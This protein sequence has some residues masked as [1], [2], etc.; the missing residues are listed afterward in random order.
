[1]VLFLLM[2]FLYYISIDIAVPIPRS[3]ILPIVSILYGLPLFLTSMRLGVSPKVVWR[4]WTALTVAFALSVVSFLYAVGTEVLP[5]P[6]DEASPSLPVRVM[7]YNIHSAY[8]IEGR[9]NPEEIARVIEASGAD[10][11]ALQ[12]VSRGWLI[13][14]ST[15]LASW[16]ARRLNMDVLFKGTTGPV[17]GNAIL[18]RYPIMD[19][20]SG[21]LPLD[22]SLLGRGYLWAKIDVGARQP[23]QIIA[24]H[25]HHVEGE[26][27]I[28]LAQVPVL[29][30]YWDH[31]PRSII[32]GD[33]NA[34]PGVAEIALFFQAGLIDSWSEVGSGDGY[35]YSSGDPYQRIDWIWHT[36]D[37]VASDVEILQST[38]SDHLPVVATVDETH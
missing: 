19:H 21:A 32:M 34:E 7:T 37:L 6:G 36:Q 26:G 31:A 17:W 2:A 13:E 10:I 15:D 23:L 22:G 20:G 18:T 35:T 25:L 9:Q 3:T 33:M 11:I 5:R 27:E 14:G 1:M 28:R 24:T 8:N 38:A 30:E 12:E 16:L 29:I 4:D